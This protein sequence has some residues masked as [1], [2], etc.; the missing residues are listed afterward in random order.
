M[1]AVGFGLALA[2]LLISPG[3]TNTLLAIGGASVGFRRGLPLIVAALAG[4]LLVIVPVAILGGPIL[5]AQPAISAVLALASAA[6]VLV[7]AVGLWHGGPGGAGT[8]FVSFGGVLATT[9]LNPKALIIGLVL[10]PA[11]DLAGL[12]PWLGLFAVIAATCTGLWLGAGAVLGRA[13]AQGLPP[14]LR[15]IAAAYLGL[16]AAGLALTGLGGV[17]V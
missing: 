16:V 3:P 11:T 5:A 10:L 2:A 1:T 13:S 4:Y 9:I 17:G 14:A 7:L 8:A 15:R 6:W 12:L